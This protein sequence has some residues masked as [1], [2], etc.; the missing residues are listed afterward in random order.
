MADFRRPAPLSFEGNVAENWRRFEEDF[1]IF[2]KAAHAGKSDA[3]H[4]YTLLNIAG[5]EAIIKSRGFTYKPA[6]VGQD[7]E[8]I[9]P[10]ESKEDPNVMKFRELCAPQRNVIIERH[11][12]SETS[13]M[14]HFQVSLLT[15]VRSHNTANMVT[16]MM[17]LSEID[18]C[19]VSNDSL[20]RSMLKEADLVLPKAIQMGQIQEQSETDAHTL[21]QNSATND[22]TAVHDLHRARQRRPS[23]TQS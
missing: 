19:G 8:V 17:S 18:S 11:K 10:A 13:Y 15:Y 20:R 16:R 21:K 4:A 2:F 6:R 12:V 5:P 1:D 22:G 7:G 23:S 3:E 9:T 14:N